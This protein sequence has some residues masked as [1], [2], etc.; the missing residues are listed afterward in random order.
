MK[1]ALLRFWNTI[2]FPVLM[3]IVAALAMTFNA[4]KQ[5]GDFS[6][7]LSFEYWEG[8]AYTSSVMLIPALTAALDKYLRGQGIYME[9]IFNGFKLPEDLG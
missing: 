3:L 6:L 8:M 9:R 7:V 5:T 4:L 1:D 2:K